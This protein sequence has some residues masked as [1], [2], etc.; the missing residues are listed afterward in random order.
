MKRVDVKTNFN[1]NNQCRFCVQG[2][3]RDLYPPKTTKEIKNIL[4]QSRMTHE[5]VVFTGGE[6]TI[7]EDIIELVKFARLLG[8]RLIQIQSNGRMFCYEKFCDKI[9]A[10]G[11]N[12]FSPALHGHIPALHDFLTRSKGSFL[13]TLTGIKNLKK[14]KQD[15][16]INCVVTKPN[17]RNL[18][19]I[20]RLLVQCRVDQYQFAFVHAGGRAGENFDSIVPRKSLAVPFIKKGLDIGIKAGVKVM[21]EAVPF[22]LMQG[23]EDYI[24]E[25]YI[26]STKIYDAGSVVDDFA[27]V[28]KSEGKSKGPL[29]R[30][31]SHYNICEG[32]WKEYPQQF[33]WDEFVPLKG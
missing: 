11:A 9:I 29:C 20:A 5:G 32:P 19:D 17:Y 12:Q 23:Y 1:C 7:R 10:A 24:A 15:V 21:V 6:V 22:C 25:K 13:Q 3:K 16:I 4:K 8:Y 28:R 31:C 18:P 30:K 26:P 27:L 33:G 2:N 14:R